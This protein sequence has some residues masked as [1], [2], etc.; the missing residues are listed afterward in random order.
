MLKA[1]LH[2]LLLV[3]VVCGGF[4]VLERRDNPPNGFLRVGPSPPATILNLRLALTQNDM[5]GLQ[6]TVYDVSTPGNARYGQYLSKEQ[7][8]GF[9]APSQDTLNGVN[10]WLKTNN[11][12]SSPLTAAGD[13]IAVSLTVSQ[14][15]TLLAA[16]FS[17]FQ[18][19]GTNQTV[20][21]TLSYSIPTTLRTSINIIYPTVTF[22]VAKHPSI[23]KKTSAA[24]RPNKRTSAISSDCPGNWTPACIQELYGIPS[25]PATPTANTLGVCGFDNE[26]VDIHDLTAFLK[27]YRPD[28]DSNTTFSLISIDD[29]INNQLPSGA[30]SGSSPMIQYAVGLATGVPVVFIS[31]G[32]GQTGSVDTFTAFLDEPNYLLS[33]AQP[34]QTVVQAFDGVSFEF[35]SD[36]TPQL[37]ESICNSYAQLAA[38]GVSYIV[39][40]G[41]FGAANPFSPGGCLAWDVSFPASCPFVTAVSATEFL[42]NEAS[43]GAMSNAGS[44]GT[45]GGGFSN[46]FARPR[47]QDTVVPAYLKAIG[48]TDAS[49][50]NISGRAIPDISAI[51]H[52]P[53]I[54]QGE[55]VTSQDGTNFA[56]TIFASMIALLTNERIAAGKPGLGFLNPLI[57][58]NPTAFNDFPTGS[59]PGCNDA[60]AFNG[61]VGWD[62]VTGFGS[63]NYAKLRDK[64]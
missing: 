25:T 9:V 19:A 39:K 7:V 45:A 64:L 8:E 38:R 43:E 50:F 63:P 40:G 57:Y 61:T 44:G 29:G 21:R 5:A 11:L 54:F 37:A 58:Q 14:A 48:A 6:E 59:N 46:I 24:S 60:N 20:H 30:S 28:I 4:V 10:S 22:P 34:P 23:R 2:V 35:E 36:F 41:D 33:L 15:N 1:L 49:P 32:T 51:G 3:T 62:A 47:Y 27:T 12:T 31:T 55:T 17:T 16:D 56:A 18:N 42:A 26:F 53:F 13:W 52:S